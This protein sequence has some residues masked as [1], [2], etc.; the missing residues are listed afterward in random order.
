[1]LSWMIFVQALKFATQT[2]E[3]QSKQNKTR[4]SRTLCFCDHYPNKKNL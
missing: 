4:R 1:M 2:T 3:T